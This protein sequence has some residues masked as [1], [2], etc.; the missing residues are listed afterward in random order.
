MLHCDFPT[1]DFPTVQIVGLVKHNAELPNADFPYGTNRCNPK[2]TNH[3]ALPSGFNGR[4]VL[5]AKHRQV[6]MAPKEPRLLLPFI[7]QGTDF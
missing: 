7:P 1:A 3:R 6:L 5:M 2:S 4:Q